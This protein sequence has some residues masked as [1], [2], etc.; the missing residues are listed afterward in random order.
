MAVGGSR[1]QGRPGGCR[2]NMPEAC[3]YVVGIVRVV[4]A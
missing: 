4:G 3:P 1:C 2:F